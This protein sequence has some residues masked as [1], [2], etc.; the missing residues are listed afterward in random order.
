MNPKDVKKDRKMIE[1]RKTD[2]ALYLTIAVAGLITILFIFG[3]W[4]WNFSVRQNLSKT[5]RCSNCL[6]SL[7]IHQTKKKI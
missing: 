2:V 6:T 1:S 7:K 5:G 3:L 4:V